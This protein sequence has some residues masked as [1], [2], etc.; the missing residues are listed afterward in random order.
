MEGGKEQNGGNPG[1]LDS[2]LSW[3]KRRQHSTVD[4]IPSRQARLRGRAVFTCFSQ[5]AQRTLTCRSM[6]TSNKNHESCEVLHR[7]CIY[8]TAIPVFAESEGEGESIYREQSII[9]YALWGV[10]GEKTSSNKS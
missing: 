5:V 4:H 1:W 8:W 9:L 7:S 10:Q 3:G 2:I 6:A